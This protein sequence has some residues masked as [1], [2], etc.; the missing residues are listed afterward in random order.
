MEPRQALPT[1]QP[2]ETC[3]AK[4][5][6]GTIRASG[7]ASERNYATSDFVL[8]FL[9]YCKKNRLILVWWRQKC[10]CYRDGGMLLAVAGSH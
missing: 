5:K 9:F 10:R 4:I 2:M 1:P 6:K 8:Y 3:L 7:L